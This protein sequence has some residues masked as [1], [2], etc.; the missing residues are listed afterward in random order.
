MYIWQT[1]LWEKIRWP[2]IPDFPGQSLFLTSSPGKNQRSPGTPICPVFGL[3]SR[4][5]PDLTCA[6][7]KCKHMAMSTNDGLSCLRTSTSR[8]YLVLM[9]SRWS[10]SVWVCQELM[11]PPR[12]FS[13]WWMTFGQVKE[14]QMNTDTV[15]NILIT[16]TNFDVSC[17]DFHTL[18]VTHPRLLKAIHSSEKY[19]PKPTV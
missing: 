10:S 11:L 2:S 12:E 1:Y 14:T 3:A 13:R 6:R 17:L 4:I 16:R 18:L 15:T 19:K 8:I 9:S 7:W 5:C